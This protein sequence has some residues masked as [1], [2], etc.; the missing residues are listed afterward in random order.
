MRTSHS[1]AQLTMYNMTHKSIPLVIVFCLGFG[2]SSNAFGIPISF[3]FDG[4]SATD[5]DTD[6]ATNVSLDVLASG[7]ILDL[8]VSILLNTD[9]DPNVKWDDI[10]MFIS[11][12]GG[13]MERLNLSFNGPVAATL[14]DV[15]Y[16]DEATEI[17][18]FGGTGD[19]VGTF[20]PTFG[21]LG[22]FDGEDIGGLW[23]LTFSDTTSFLENGN[24]DLVSWRIFGEADD[25]VVSVPEPGTL[26]L[27]ILG[28]LGLGLA[29][30][31]TT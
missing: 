19:A 30:R 10:D 7:S 5:V 18:N 8:N 16:D 1:V 23:T 21:F 29:R 17:T 11:H 9:S 20:L 2:L 3:S 15:T 12:N 26:A 13:P 28:L 24:D 6:P 14:F 31:R 25:L 27:F 22:N 4:P